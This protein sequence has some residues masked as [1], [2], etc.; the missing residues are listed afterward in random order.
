MILNTFRIKNVFIKYRTALALSIQR[1]WGACEG[2]LCS[3]FNERTCT[4]LQYCI[5]LRRLVSSARNQFCEWRKLLSE[6]FLLTLVWVVAALPTFTFFTDAADTSD[7]ETEQIS[8][9][10]WYSFREIYR[11]QSIALPGFII[12][13][14]VAIA[15]F[16]WW[17]LIITFTSVVFFYRH[18]YLW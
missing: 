8:I 1:N 16:V 14:V 4:T 13:L 6:L 2:G 11:S 7:L 17:A 12:R 10:C 3:R 9:C 5:R 18:L 15:S